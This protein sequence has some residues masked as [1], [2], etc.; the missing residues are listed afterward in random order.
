MRCLGMRMFRTGTEPQI[1]SPVLPGRSR[2]MVPADE[3]R[4]SHCQTA[5]GTAYHLAAL[6]A[7]TL[8]T[9]WWRED[10]FQPLIEHRLRHVSQLHVWPWAK[11]QEKRRCL[12]WMN[13]AR[14]AS[15]FP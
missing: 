6:S 2:I 11:L 13:L 7:A 10:A 15:T 5:N 8:I 9:C 4:G 1:A 14:Y 12:P 3:P